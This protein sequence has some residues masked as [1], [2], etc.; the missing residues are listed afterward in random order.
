[1][2]RDKPFTYAEFCDPNLALKRYG[3]DEALAIYAERV[4]PKFT[5]SNLPGL[6]PDWEWRNA[7]VFFRDEA[8]CQ[9]CGLDVTE[10]EWVVHHIVPRGRGGNH[11][12][13]NLELL[14]E[15]CHWRKHPE[16]HKPRTTQSR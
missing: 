2:Q 3:S 5:N 9:S 8:L 12:L 6:P 10:Q 14:C 15:Y 16:K 1:M 7:F 13:R 11:D 4:E